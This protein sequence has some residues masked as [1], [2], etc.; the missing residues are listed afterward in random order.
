M[1]LPGWPRVA[2]HEH[3]AHT[4]ASTRARPRAM[5]V[6]RWRLRTRTDGAL[7]HTGVTP[8]RGQRGSDAAQGK[9]PHRQRLDGGGMDGVDGG[10]VGGDV[11]AR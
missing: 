4:T 10:V 8:A 11:A 9:S 3:A 5:P 7:R 6:A 2:A 1:V